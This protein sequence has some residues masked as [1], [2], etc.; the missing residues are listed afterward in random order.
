MQQT[1]DIVKNKFTGA[2]YSLSKIE[3]YVIGR[4]YNVDNIVLSIITIWVRSGNKRA[5]KRMTKRMS[6][7]QLEKNFITLCTCNAWSRELLV[8]VA[9]ANIGIDMARLR[10][11]E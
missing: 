1:L 6:T 11:E 4:G 9:I 7:N 3:E 2:S 5:T 10:G 8:D